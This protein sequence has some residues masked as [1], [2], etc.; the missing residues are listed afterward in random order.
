[1]NPGDTQFAENRTVYTHSSVR[2]FVYIKNTGS[3]P[4]DLSLVQV[5]VTSPLKGGRGCIN[6]SL[7]PGE[8]EYEVI[9]YFGPGGLQAGTYQIVAQV[10]SNN[11]IVE[12]DEQNNSFSIPLTVQ[13]SNIYSGQPDLVIQ[14]AALATPLNYNSA[15]EYI[16]QV[17]N[18]GT[19]PANIHGN[20]IIKANGNLTILQA[21]NWGYYVVIKPG[22][23]VTLHFPTKL[24]IPLQK[25]SYDITFTCDPNNNLTESN[26]M[27][28]IYKVHLE[29]P[30]QT[31]VNGVSDLAFKEA[32]IVHTKSNNLY[33]L[34]AVILNKGN[35]ALNFS[36]NQMVWKATQGLWFYGQ[37][38][39]IALTLKPG[40]SFIPY[41]SAQKADKFISGTTMTFELKL[42]P[43]NL[44]TATDETNN[45]FVLTARI[46]EDVVDR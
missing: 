5:V 45:T 8:E 18:N 26:E 33:W 40:E 4:V 35:N 39:N 34:E 23:I 11:Q 46:P 14:S 31:A 20:L 19:F 9:P 1:M 12:S 24:S 22:E 13:P 3:T 37:I 21:E 43:N 28:N 6:K 36:P 15:P 30:D 42:D 44:I 17:K 7:A 27:N 25:G 29:I 41:G 32:H 10:D 2:L 16:V 38:N